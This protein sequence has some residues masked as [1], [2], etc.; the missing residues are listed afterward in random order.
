MDC[1]N[2][3]VE[4]VMAAM[5]VKF[6]KYAASKDRDANT[7]SY[8]ELYAMAIKE[9]PTLCSSTNKDE[10]LKG[11]IGKMDANNDKLVDFEEFMC[12]VACVTIAVRKITKK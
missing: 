4:D 2:L 5:I 6:E 3:T 10:I 11:I 12:F 9:F 1:S 7:M 8:D